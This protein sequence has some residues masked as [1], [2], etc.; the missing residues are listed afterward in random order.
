MS[1]VVPKRRKKAPVKERSFDLEQQKIMLQELLDQVLRVGTFESLHAL[2]AHIDR[3]KATRVFPLDER[4]KARFEAAF[5][6]LRYTLL[7]QGQECDAILNHLQEVTGILPDETRHLPEIQKCIQNS[8]ETKAGLHPEE[9]VSYLN[10]VMERASGLGLSIYSIWIRYVS[11]NYLYALAQSLE[12]ADLFLAQVAVFKKWNLLGEHL[13]LKEGS[14]EYSA[15]IRRQVSL[16][17]LSFDVRAAE[18]VLFPFEKRSYYPALV[19]YAAGREERQKKEGEATGVLS[20]GDSFKRLADSIGDEY[21]KQEA[22]MEMPLTMLLETDASLES[23]ER[24]FLHLVQYSGVHTM[25]SFLRTAFKLGLSEDRLE[26]VIQ[27]IYAHYIRERGLV[28]DEFLLE[29]RI[30]ILWEHPAIQAARLALTYAIVL[31]TKDNLTQMDGELKNRPCVLPYNEWPATLQN[32]FQ[33]HFRERGMEEK[34]HLTKRSIQWGDPTDRKR[35]LLSIIEN[36][37]GMQP[38][39][40]TQWIERYFEDIPVF[41]EQDP[42]FRASYQKWL[43]ACISDHRTWPLSSAKDIPGSDFPNWSETVYTLFIEA[44]VKAYRFKDLEELP[45][46]VGEREKTIRWYIDVAIGHRISDVLISVDTGTELMEY[47]MKKRP[48]ILKKFIEKD[49]DHNQDYQCWIAN[50]YLQGFIEDIFD[51]APYLD[52]Q[53]FA[54]QRAIAI[55]Y[56]KRIVRCDV[57]VEMAEAFANEEPYVQ[58]LKWQDPKLSAEI[59]ALFQKTLGTLG[60]ALKTK[61]EP[62]LI[63]LRKLEQD[64]GYRS[65]DIRH[66]SGLKDLAG[67]TEALSMVEAWQDIAAV[68]GSEPEEKEGMLAMMQEYVDKTCSLG[69]RGPGRVEEFLEVK[70]RLGI[71]P[72]EGALRGRFTRFMA[73]QNQPQDSL[74]MLRAFDVTMHFTT[75]EISALPNA[76]LRIEALFALAVL[77]KSGPERV[78]AEKALRGRSWRADL[79]PPLLA[80]QSP[81]KREEFCPYKLTLEP[82]L[83]TLSES[84]LSPEDPAARKGLLFFLQRFGVHYTPSLAL[85]VMRLFLQTQNGRKPVDEEA[86]LV[87]EFRAFLGLKEGEHPPFEHYLE[88]IESLMDQMRQMILTDVPLEAHI[89]RSALG[90]ELFNALVPHV[91]SYK[92]V[93]DRPLLLSIARQNKAELQVDPVYTALEKPV[94]ILDQRSESV[95]GEDTS[96]VID[97]GIRACREQKI[98]KYNDETLQRFLGGWDK[99]AIN[100]ELEPTGSSRVYWF[101]PLRAQL[102]LR[103]ESLGKKINGLTH[104]IA[105]ERA[106]KELGRITALREAVTRLIEEPQPG[107]PEQLLEELQ[108]LYVNA[109]GKID[110]VA[111]E[112]EAGDVARALTL[113]VMRTRSPFHFDVV[114]AVRGAGEQQFHPVSGEPLLTPAQVGA[115]SIWFAEEYLEHFAGIRDQAQAPLSDV[116]RRLLQKLWR[117]DGFEEELR[118]WTPASKPIAHPILGPTEAIRVLDQEIARLEKRELVYEE[119]PVGFW[120]VKGIGRALAGDIADA[121]Y[122]GYRNNILRGEYPGI[123]AVLMTLPEHSEI[124]GSVLFIDTKTA[125]TDKRV[126]VIR[127]LNPTEAVTRRFLDARSFVEATIEYAKE[128]ALRSQGDA[129][130]IAEIRLCYDHRGGHSTNREEIFGAMKQLVEHHGWVSGEDLVDEPET[131]FNRYEIYHAKET[132]VVWH[133]KHP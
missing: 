100:L 81:T 104:A 66:W 24:V 133:V 85:N 56:L 15:W 63:L 99:A 116:N 26:G 64:T 53:D 40:A 54:I 105:I 89:E 58:H 16:H 108:S 19:E 68:F 38:G 61:P 121:C 95:L 3:L 84:N 52:L 18:Q 120:P 114:K 76:P 4:M 23:K 109:S 92:E 44:L 119:K 13:I 33:E 111:L 97:R 102:E 14:Q 91:G 10:R 88:R 32:A 101:S 21:V 60:R 25:E 72:C 130:P 122:H 49:P 45:L 1:E 129:N 28:P 67:L 74:E 36:D 9:V 6:E 27:E 42:H 12:K 71:Q 50:V 113:I 86:L 70:K 8:I 37:F 118:N 46:L 30:P 7:P 73:L 107:T 117:I 2:A 87:P 80:I 127:A 103:E 59:E 22:R 47:L 110:R 11:Q 82:L 78:E 62:V 20:E 126:L 90:M 17:G 29:R 125:D 132:R 77:P 69:A 39:T 55:R 115:W 131:N 93:K 41:C 34:G 98:R 5:V 124:A 75:A 31:K 128:I 79:I 123:T 51:K 35:L 96:L 106:N 112:A 65:T 83:D 94:R 48:D 43:S 57:S